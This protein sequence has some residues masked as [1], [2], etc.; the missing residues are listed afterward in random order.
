MRRRH[1]NVVALKGLRQ[2]TILINK[3]TSPLRPLFKNPMSG[4][5]SGIFSVFLT[6]VGVPQRY[7]LLCS[8]VYSLGQYGHQTIQLPILLPVLLMSSMVSYFIFLC[9][10]SHEIVLMRYGTEL[11]QYLS[12]ILPTPIMLLRK[13]GKIYVAAV[14]NWIAE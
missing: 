14:F 3:T 10:F 6:S 13:K 2:H 9:P 8:C 12:I 11:S 5:N 1:N 4:L 7:M